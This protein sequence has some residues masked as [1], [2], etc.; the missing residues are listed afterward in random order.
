MKT[1][2]NRFL[3]CFYLLFILLL[4]F[5]SLYIYIRM[6]VFLFLVSDGGGEGW[7]IVSA[8][9]CRRGT[10]G[11]SGHISWIVCLFE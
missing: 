10:R 1:P 7:L 11:M 9:Q 6:C 5:F 8:R 3:N 2:L 4:T